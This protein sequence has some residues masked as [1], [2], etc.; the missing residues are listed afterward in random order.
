MEIFTGLM[1]GSLEFILGPF[2]DHL[3]GT[4]VLIGSYNF[5]NGVIHHL[6]N[7]DCYFGNGHI[8]RHHL[9]CYG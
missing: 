5:P 2:L 7:R 9:L 8:C 6:Q 4:N 3:L 1:L